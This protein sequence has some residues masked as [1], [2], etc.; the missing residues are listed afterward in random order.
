MDRKYYYVIILLFCFVSVRL[1]PAF[2]E[3]AIA[4]ALAN[5]SPLAALALCG[6]M[7]L[8]LRMAAI[9]TFG[10]FLISDVVLNIK[11]GFA[12]INVY[13]LFL[14]FVFTLLYW[15]GHLLRN[16]KNIIVLLAS[17]FF[18]SIIF[19][20][21]ANTV[22]FFFDPGYLKNISGWLMANT[23]GLPGYPP[24]W[25][26]GLKSLLSNII[27]ASAF[28]FALIPKHETVKITGIQSQEV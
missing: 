24:A 15:L 11:Y 20:I 1:L 16:K 25:L 26:F 23:T 14:L 10:T 2:S 13:S 17:T 21:S 9:L 3:T 28:Y 6:A 4:E 7:L 12:I 5:I 8:P 22:S 18:S 19:Y 27:F